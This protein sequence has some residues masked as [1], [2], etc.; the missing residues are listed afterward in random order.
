MNDIDYTTAHKLRGTVSLLCEE[1]YQW[2]MIV[3]Q[4]TQPELVTWDYFKSAFQSKYVG[5][6]YVEAH[7]REFMSVVQGER[8]I[9]E[10]EAEFFRLSRYARALVV[11]EYNKCVRFEDGLRFD[12]RVLIAPQREWV[13]IDLVDKANIVEDVKHT[14][15]E[16][17]DR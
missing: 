10:Y 16:W 4:G 8:S 12:L 13:F 9:A 5:A 14:E 11:T 15:R 7:R 2:W 17:R 6:N 3:E 1:A